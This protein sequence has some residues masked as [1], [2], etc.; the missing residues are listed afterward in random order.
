MMKAE[1]FLRPLILM[2]YTFF[3]GVPC[4]FLKPIINYVIQS[5]DLD[6]IIASSEGEAVGIA[7]GAH[8]AGEKAVV[9]C[10]NS[11]L[12]NMINPLTSL[13]YPFKIPFLLI[14]TLRG[15]P[16]INDEPQHELMGRITGKLLSTIGI[17]WKFFPDQANKV[18]AEL[19]E[20]KKVME[21]LS[22]PFAFIMR[23]GAVEPYPLTVKPK[24]TRL[25]ENVEI[26]GNFTCNKDKMMSR[27]DAIKGIR[28]SISSD[29]AVV[30]TT[31]KIGRELF[32]MGDK[33]N[34]IYVVG[35]MGCAS[36]IGFGI[37]IT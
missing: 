36:S 12:G 11:G 8:L 19:N 7:A 17:Q 4:S 5:D 20:A 37:Q 29:D 3:T 35:S 28:E 30:A 34:Q 23:K 22:L 33:G 18:V 27:I 13:N 10:Q 1:N 31:G 14:I 24:Q 16:G 26:F 9:M 6:Y 21:Q 25:Y 2:G 15:E 32:S